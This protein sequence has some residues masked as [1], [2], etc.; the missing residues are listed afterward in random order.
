MLKAAN[1]PQQ[2]LYDLSSWFRSVFNSIQSGILIIDAE[3]KT[4]VDVNP[5]A[6]LMLG[7]DRENIVGNKCSF[8]GCLAGADDKCPIIDL[9]LDI[10]NKTCVLTRRDG[11]T[12]QVAATITSILWNNKRYLIENFINITDLKEQ[13]EKNWKEVETL[14]SNNIAEMKNIIAKNS[15]NDGAKIKKDLHFALNIMM[16]A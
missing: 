9:G 6:A 13:Y 7:L 1:K 10:E 14:L 15:I 8:F 4:I 16:E 3:T 11:T 12:L 2:Y 5:A